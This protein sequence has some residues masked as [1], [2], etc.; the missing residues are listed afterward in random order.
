M[1]LNPRKYKEFNLLF[2]DYIGC[3]KDEDGGFIL[4]DG[5]KM[6]KTMH[7]HD[8]WDWLM[9][10]VENITAPIEISYKLYVKIV[11]LADVDK[12][13]T[14]NEEKTLLLNMYN[15]CYQYIK[16][17]KDETVKDCVDRTQQTEA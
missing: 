9:T 11:D 15:A 12:D 10:V 6:A 2:A 8:R 14:S 17:L 4:P 13:I 3:T 5:T 7:F 16:K 1:I